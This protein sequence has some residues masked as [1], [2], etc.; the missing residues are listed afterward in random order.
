MVKR[1]PSQDENEDED[2]DEEQELRLD[3]PRIVIER[4]TPQAGPRR[5]GLLLSAGSG[6]SRN[7]TR[8][9]TT[10]GF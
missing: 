3:R 8:T 6:G 7:N 9:P 2:D 4:R 5:G 10:H 1:V